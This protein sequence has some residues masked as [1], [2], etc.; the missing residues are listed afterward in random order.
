MR[1]ATLVLL[2]LS[3]STQAAWDP[4]SFQFGRTWTGPGDYSDADYVTIWI[5][6][7]SQKN[8]QYNTYW[9]GDMLKTCKSKNK[10]AVLYA[11]II[12]FVAR[13]KGGLQDC[14]VAGKNSPSSLCTQGAKYIRSNRALILDTYS[15]FAT[16]VAKDWGTS[17]PIVWLLEPDFYQYTE[18]SSYWGTMD[19]PLT[20]KEA[21]DLMSDI[22]SRIKEK[23][24]NARLSLDISPWMGG[25]SW[26]N[27]QTAW[28]NAMPKS[29]FSYRHT[30]GGRTEGNNSRIRSDAN[31]LTTWAG[32]YGISK[33]G[34]IADDGYGVGGAANGEWA[35]WFSA[36]N[37]NAR[38]KDGVIAVTVAEP[39]GGYADKIRSARSSIT[40]KLVTC[41][42]STD[43]DPTYK[44]TLAANNGQLTATPTPPADGY[45]KGTTVSITAKADN[46]YQ[47]TGWTGACSGTGN[48]SVTMNSDQSVGATFTASQS[49]TYTLTLSASNGQLTASPAPPAGGY[50][51]GATVTVTAKAD[52]GFEFSGWTG[53]CSGTS[54]CSV[55]MNSNLS[56]GAT[57]K[58]ASVVA[59]HAIN[60]QADHGTLVF[61]P[62]G[63]EFAEGS[64]VKVT[65]K[66]DEGYRF[67]GWQGACSGTG[68]CSLTIPNYSPWL[69]ANFEKIILGVDPRDQR[70]RWTRISGDRL[71]L[72]LP[73]AGSLQCTLIGM[74]G[75]RE[76]LLFQGS[77]SETSLELDLPPWARGLYILEIVGNGFRHSESVRL[78]L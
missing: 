47:F 72:N 37:L 57:F 64:T 48:C 52:N 31:N 78:G 25:T 49:S 4:C 9:E 41:G 45:A 74:D 30:S 51:K 40:E 3:L 7:G 65:A 33:L 21:A 66:P 17:E 75:R 60:A 6:D 55:T 58:A 67:T 23:L 76:A 59:K 20:T 11:Y 19:S 77:I 32:I 70:D 29:S 8:N 39:G 46:G 63:P 2:L 1:L 22:S 69:G 24:P 18:A 26:Q 73:E 71:V 15:N 62:A 61:D 50:A 38:I 44:L 34:I 16:G 53:A 10:N 12:A 56:V 35:E 13:N 28:W 43:P 42:A 54:A 27:E 68:E 5:G 36:S 14:D